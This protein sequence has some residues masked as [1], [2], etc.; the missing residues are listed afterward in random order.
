[1]NLAIVD[2]QAITPLEYIVDRL[3]IVIE[4]AISVAF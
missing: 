3:G 2:E 1:V 4:V